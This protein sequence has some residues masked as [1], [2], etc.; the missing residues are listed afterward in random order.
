MDSDPAT[1]PW[2]DGFREF[3]HAVTARKATALFF[4]SCLLAAIPTAGAPSGPNEGSVTVSRTDRRKFV[5]QASKPKSGI[6]K[7][8]VIA[9]GH[10]LRPPFL[11]EEKAGVLQVNG[12]AVRQ[13]LS[14]SG[15]PDVPQVDPQGKEF[16]EKKWAI[17]ERLR[18]L[19]EKGASKSEIQKSAMQSEIVTEAE[20][21][22]ERHIYLTIKRGDGD[23][24]HHG[25]DFPAKVPGAPDGGRPSPK[26]GV[27]SPLGIEKARFSGV[28]TSDETL[29]LMSDGG[30]SI[31]K[32]SAH[33]RKGVM[34]VMDSPGKSDA[35]KLVELK[36]IFRG[37]ETAASDVMANYVKAEWEMPSK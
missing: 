3:R 34:G 8:L 15:L 2:G 24:V 10:P 26:P 27:Q 29:I 22:G 13:N 30:I 7:G 23:V 20:W 11:L 35:E 12:I 21:R 28:L 4:I 18:G 19:Y 37:A 1:K 32:P 16:S 6:N 33:L 31:G 25:I 17:V 5:V 14:R 9:Y 36:R